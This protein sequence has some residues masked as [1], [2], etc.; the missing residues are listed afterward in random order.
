M[1]SGCSRSNPRKLLLWQK[2][3]HRTPRPGP[4]LADVR[5]K[6][7]NQGETTV[8]AYSSPE[9]QSRQRARS[10]FDGAGRRRAP[11]LGRSKAW[12][13]KRHRQ[14]TTTGCS[15]A[16]CRAANKVKKTA[17]TIDRRTRQR[18]SHSFRGCR[19]KHWE[20]AE[21][22]ESKETW[23]LQKDAPSQSTGAIKQPGRPRGSHTTTAFPN[24]RCAD[25]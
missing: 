2:D 19:R 3:S 25:C 10:Q 22:R 21:T 5:R 8:T 7:L 18:R 24:H 17:P 14:A 20:L 15:R 11:A 4:D 12:R 13:S 9:S 1:L 6:P 16:A 23:R